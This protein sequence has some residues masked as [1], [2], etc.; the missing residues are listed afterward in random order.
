MTLGLVGRGQAKVRQGQ[1]T[2]P[3]IQPEE[4][5]RVQLVDLDGSAAVHCF[6]R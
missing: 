3:A 5:G 4:L 2:M 6:C 1:K